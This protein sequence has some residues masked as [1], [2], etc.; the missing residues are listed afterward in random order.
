FRLNISALN[1]KRVARDEPTTD[2]GKQLK[3]TLEGLLEQ[4]KEHIDH[5]KQVKDS[6]FE[7]VKEIR[8]KLEDLNQDLGTKAKELLEKVKDRFK[9]WFKKIVGDLNN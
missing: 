7:K 3:K 8:D 6:L 2:L 5:G 1:L 4:I 9:D